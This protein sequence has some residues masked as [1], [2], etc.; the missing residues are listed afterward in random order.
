MCQTFNQ[1][2]GETQLRK[3]SFSISTTNIYPLS[4][5]SISCFRWEFASQEN[6]Y[7]SQVHIRLIVANR[8]TQ[9]KAGKN[10]EKPIL[11]GFPKIVQLVGALEWE[12]HPLC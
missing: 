8:E 10:D 7:T 4:E 12:N 11:H 3:T 2:A 1:P 5:K 9:Q 6:S